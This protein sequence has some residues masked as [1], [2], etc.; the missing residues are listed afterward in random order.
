[1]KG[2]SYSLEISEEAEIDFNDAYEYYYDES[3]NVADAFFQRIN[4]SFEII[5]KSPLLFQDIHNTLRK[6]TVK[7]FPFVIYYQIVGCSIKIIAI[8]HSSRNPIIWKE[9]IED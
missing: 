8:F 7:Q 9:R 4:A 2:R 6:F 1:M 3:P 5:K